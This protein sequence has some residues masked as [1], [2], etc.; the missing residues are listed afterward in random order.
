LM[1][2]M[3]LLKASG[4]FGAQGVNG[5]LSTAFTYA[6]AA[7][8]IDP[9]GAYIHHKLAQLHL[10]NGNKDSALYYANKAVKIAPNWACALTLLAKIQN[11][12]SNTN[13]D[14]PKK[15]GVN[16]VRKISFGGTIGGGM[17]QS[18]PTYSGNQNS[19]I[20]GVNSNGAGLFDAG[21]IA[22]I[23][24]GGLIYVRPELTVSIENTSVEFEHRAPTGGPITIETVDIKTTSAVLGIPL[25]VRLSKKN[26]APYI[27]LGPA[28]NYVFSQDADSKEKIPIN[29]S[30]FMGSAGLGLDIGIAKSGLVISPEVRYNAGFSEMRDDAAGTLYTAGMS[31]LK[32][33]SFSLNVF[34]RKR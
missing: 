28:I 1:N 12:T 11:T 19:G 7:L 29:K 30:L 33:N 15:P 23:N 20:A 22:Q 24:I 6:F 5:Q 21:F 31:S 2:R 4:D 3:Y 8:K 18:N 16:P 32:K 17:T 34:I 25:I 26:S 27:S 9:D 13:P 14:I 10:Q